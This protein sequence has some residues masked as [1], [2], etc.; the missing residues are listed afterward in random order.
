MPRVMKVKH[1]IEELQKL[2]PEAD[3][4]VGVCSNPGRTVSKYMYADEIEI[5]QRSHG[6]ATAEVRILG[7]VPAGEIRNP[8][9]SPPPDER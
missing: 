6:E 1:L 5:M 4:C 8:H 3:A 9:D 7:V 2:D